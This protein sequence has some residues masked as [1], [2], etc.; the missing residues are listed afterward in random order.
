MAEFKSL[1]SDPNSDSEPNAIVAYNGRQIIDANPIATVA[2]TQ[3]QLEDPEESEAE[4]HL[5]HSH[6]WVKGMPLH[7]VVDN[8]SQKNLISVEFIKRLELPT[9]PHRQPY[10][11]GWLSQGR[12]ICITQ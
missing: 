7:F 1:E 9:T 4:E 11:I 8:D 12:G 3:I 5:L 2:T 10:S 6:M